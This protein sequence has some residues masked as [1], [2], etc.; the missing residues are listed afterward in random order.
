MKFYKNLPLKKIKNKIQ[1]IPILE[2]NFK[3]LGQFKKKTI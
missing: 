2:M 1:K 3:F